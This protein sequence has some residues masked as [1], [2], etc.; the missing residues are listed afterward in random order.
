LRLVWRVL[1]GAVVDVLGSSD[2]VCATF[3]GWCDYVA[4]EYGVFDRIWPTA[5]EYVS[6]NA[7]CGYVRV[8][9]VIDY[10]FGVRGE[11]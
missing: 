1:L 11:T 6:R 8:F 9:G 4:R 7:L 2:K 10:D 3:Y 5:E